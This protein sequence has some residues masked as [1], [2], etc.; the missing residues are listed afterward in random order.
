[1]K[2]K[3]EPFVSADAWILLAIIYSGSE[4]GDTAM[5]VEV[6][7]GINHAIPTDAELAGAFSRLK[8]SGLIEEHSGKIKA[9]AVVMDFYSRATT[10]QKR[11]YKELGDI[12]RFLGVHSNRT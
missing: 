4:G 12:E 10:P 9:A 6:A 11:I 2:R 8:G 1:M 5:I 3:S 7:D